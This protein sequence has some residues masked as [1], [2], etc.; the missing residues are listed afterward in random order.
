MSEDPSSIDPSDKTWIEKIAQTLC[1]EPKTRGDL[2]AV[3]RIAGQNEIID[4]DVLAIIEGAME[5]AEMQVREVMI[6]RSQIVAVKA[7]STAVEALP[8]IIKSGHSRFPVIDESLDEIK[9]ILL[10]KDLLPLALEQE[11]NNI[12]INKLLRPATKVPESKRLNVLLKEFREQHSHMAIVID[13]YG[14][15][16][17]LVTIEDVLE[18]IVGEIE[19]EYD[20]ETDPFI[21]QLSNKDYIIKALTPIEEFNAKFQAELSDEEFDTIGGLIMQNFGHVPHR[22][23]VTTIEDFQFKVLIS[24]KRRI[25]LLRLT[26]RNENQDE[27]QT[28]QIAD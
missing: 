13:E 17:G 4:S 10:A 15:V 6:P 19:D 3:L 27:Q 12:D 9:G 5:V 20:G 1:A 8:Q 24:D 23:E 11:I 21:K 18:E 7:D 14:G 26:L 2:L 25:H 22:N 16:S 28:E